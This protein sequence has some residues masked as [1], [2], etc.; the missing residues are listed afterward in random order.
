MASSSAPVFLAE[1]AN[2]WMHSNA[3][4][5]S[6]ADGNLILSVR[7]LDAAFKIDYADGAGTGDVVWR[8]GR[9]GDFAM[10]DP[11]GDP[12]PWFSHTHYTHFEEGRFV[13]YDNGNSRVDEEG[14]GNSRAQVYF[15]DE[16]NLIA[17]LLR[18][19]GL[20]VY[21]RAVGS[22]ELLSNGSLSTNNSFL[23]SN[24]YPI[25]PPDEIATLVP[26]VLPNGDVTYTFATTGLVYRSWRMKSLYEPGS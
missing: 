1:I 12:F 22:A 9:G 18:N 10:I 14:G 11:S 6:P 20:G 2:D 7:H 16:T 26:E 25:L 19:Q 8:M 15:V 23:D 24:D 21:S 17:V 13:V 3:L 4:D 5:Y